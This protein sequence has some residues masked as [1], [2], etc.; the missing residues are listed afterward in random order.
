MLF[1]QN[2]T[3]PGYYVYFYLRNNG[4]PYYIGIGQKNRA[5]IDHRYK[6]K[7]TGY[8]SGVHTPKDH[9]RILILEWDL[10][11]LWA[12]LLERKFIRWFGRKNSIENGI[13]LNKADGGQ[14]GFSKGFSTYID[15]SS[16]KTVVAHK[17]DPLIVNGTF[18]SYHAG[19]R[20]GRYGKTSSLETKAIWSQQRTGAKQSQSH[21][22]DRVSKTKKRMQNEEIKLKHKNNTSRER[23]KITAKKNK[24]LIY[25][26]MGLEYRRGLFAELAR[27]YG[28]S[29]EDVSKIF[30]N[31]SLYKEL[32]DE[33]IKEQTK[34]EQLR[35]AISKI[36]I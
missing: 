30:R 6:N 32:L 2:Y 25:E 28:K 22:D 35:E 3:P 17:N 7:R 36:S 1:T 18:I 10:T 23:Y 13:L 4:T 12:C 33:W 9:A 34:R 15:E 20:N 19:E 31:I 24:D 21:I 5:W 26:M 8:W 11:K 29:I 14:G 27:K 16:G